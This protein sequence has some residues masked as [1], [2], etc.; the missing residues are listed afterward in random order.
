MPTNKVKQRSKRLLQ[1]KLQNIKDR[2]IRGQEEMERQPR[3]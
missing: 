1:L 3:S 2:I